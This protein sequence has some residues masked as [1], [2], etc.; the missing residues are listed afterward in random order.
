MHEES[1]ET[2]VKETTAKQETEKKDRKGESSII[3]HQL[4][5]EDIEA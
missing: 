1:R 4:I 2:F 5:Q 3:K